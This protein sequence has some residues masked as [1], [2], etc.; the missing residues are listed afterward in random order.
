MTLPSIKTLDVVLIAALSAGIATYLGCKQPPRYRLL[1]MGVGLAW[2]L[3]LLLNYWIVESRKLSY[4]SIDFYAYYIGAVATNR[5]QS[6]FQRHIHNRIANEV[7]IGVTDTLAYPPT[8]PLLLRPLISTPPY[9][10]SLLWFAL[11]SAVLVASL[12]VIDRVFRLER[13][14]LRLACWMIPLL[15]APVVLGF[16]LGQINHFLLFMYSLCLLGIGRNRPILTGV[17]LALPAWIKVFP[18]ASILYFAWKRQ[19]R[20]FSSAVLGLLLVGWFTYSGSPRLTEEYFST[21]LPNVMDKPEEGVD[22]L[23]LSI[24]GVVTKILAPTSAKVIPLTRKPKLAHAVRRAA[25]LVIVLL[26]ILGCTRAI[27]FGGRG[28]PTD[29]FILV[30]IASLLILPRLWDSSLVLLLPA[31]FWIA[32]GWGDLPHPTWRDL[33]IPLTSIS[34]F[35]LHR[36][37]W[38]LANPDKLPRPWYLLCFPTIGVLLLWGL[39]VRRCVGGAAKLDTSVM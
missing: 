19:W 35:G 23:N 34:L 36:V 24:S 7:G 17:S 39:F 26:T 31:Y 1:A 21:V 27:R 33:T 12:V 25:N 11:N 13:P 8:L 29:E 14:G 32:K 20:I 9:E 38:T 30:L 10:A 22:H 3:G 2:L 16:Y 18:L 6:Y 37:I 15:F 5:E 4:T 28:T